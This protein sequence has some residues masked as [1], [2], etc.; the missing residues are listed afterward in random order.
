M[1]AP[2]DSSSPTIHRAALAQYRNRAAIYDLELAM[3]EPVRRAAVARLALHGGEVVLDLGCGTGLSMALLHSGVGTR[4]RIVGVEQSPEMMAQAQQRVQREG[5]RNVT[6]IESAVESAKI[7]RIGDAALFHF[8]HDILREPFALKN[9][10]RSLRPGAVVV[11]CGLQWASPWAWPL[12]LL[13]LGAALRSI[14]SLR[15]LD[16]PWSLLAQHL[17]GLRVDS[18]MGGS[19]YIASG[20]MRKHRGSLRDT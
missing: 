19:V 14:T 8:T 15:G 20:T 9:A 5:W 16:R 10:M 7:A 1:D 2:D 4:G 11:A 12:N 3:F 6:L 18:T 17:D 13:V